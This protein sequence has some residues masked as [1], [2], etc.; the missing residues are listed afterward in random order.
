MKNTDGKRDPIPEDFGSEEVAAA[1]WDSHSLADYEDLLESADVDVAIQRRRFEIEVEEGVFRVLTERA[2]AA[3]TSVTDL[4][5]QI[6]KEK[7][8]TA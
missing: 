5:S 3:H 7:L 2:K 8:V 1:F 4:A 6:L